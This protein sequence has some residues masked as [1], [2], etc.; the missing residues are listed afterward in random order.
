MTKG[1]AWI[2]D[3]VQGAALATQT[4]GLAIDYFGMHDT[5]PNS[6]LADRMQA[7]FKTVG[8]PKYTAEEQSFATKLQEAAGL[9]LTG[10][11]TQ[12]EAIPDEPTRGGFSDVGDV[13][14]IT[15]A[16]GIT[17]PTMPQGIALHTWMAT[18]SHGT[19]VGFKGA[20]TASKVL[21]LTGIDLLTDP[22]F[23][24]QVKA[25]FDKRTDGFTY[26]SPIPDMIKEPAVLPDEMRSYGT[27]SQLK[28]TILKSGGDDS[29]APDP[30]GHSD[31][32]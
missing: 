10:M 25:D 24:K 1:I 20:V 17:A 11:T 15:P 14:Y 16:M 26:K 22:E 9:E 2:K 21:A 29:F 8:L 4:E 12:I 27:R 23:R 18:A 28:A 30:H 5:L 32:H 19:S 31:E 7:H 3:M 13:S 6:P